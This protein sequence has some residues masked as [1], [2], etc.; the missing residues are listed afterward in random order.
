M[1]EVDNPRCVFSKVTYQ[2][3]WQNKWKRKLLHWLKRKKV[4]NSVNCQRSTLLRFILFDKLLERC[5]LLNQNPVYKPS[6]YL[7]KA[8]ATRVHCT[9]IKTLTHKW[10]YLLRR[11]LICRICIQLLFDLWS[12]ISVKPASYRPSYNQNGPHRY[13]TVTRIV[14]EIIPDTYCQE[15]RYGKI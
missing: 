12:A 10:Y 9:Q 3:L 14:V 5:T 4:F 13:N 6:V 8:R 2:N 1:L 15:T 11:H 7:Y